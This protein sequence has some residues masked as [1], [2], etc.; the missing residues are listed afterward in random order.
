MCQGRRADK[1]DG[2]TE[3]VPTLTGYIFAADTTRH[4]VGSFNKSSL[5]I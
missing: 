2:L 4:G 3:D 5:M 1:A